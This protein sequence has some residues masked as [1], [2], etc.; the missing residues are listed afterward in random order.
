VVRDGGAWRG[1]AVLRWNGA[2]GLLSDILVGPGDDAVLA[3]LLADVREVGRS[4]GLRAVRAW[5]PGR[6]PYREAFLGAGF[7]ATGQA[8]DFRYAPL[9]APAAEVDLLG[10]ADGVFHITMGDTD[11]G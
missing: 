7:R 10:S 1:Y 11:A 9:K 6:H 5:M 3:A 8:V 4:R 2:G